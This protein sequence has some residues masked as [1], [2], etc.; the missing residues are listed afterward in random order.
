MDELD[1]QFKFSDTG[2]N[3]VLGE[4]LIKVAHNQ[5][6]KSYPQLRTFLVN[7]G[8]RKFLSP[9]Y[10]EL[11]NNEKTYPLAKEIFEEARPNYHFVASSSIEKMLAR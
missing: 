11:I 3:E 1:K 8:R 10:N 2:N 5:Y 4:W 6:K 9:I 7:V